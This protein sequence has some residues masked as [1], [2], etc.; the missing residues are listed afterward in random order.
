MADEM[1]RIKAQD[2]LMVNAPIPMA[3]A[4]TTMDSASLGR[5]AQR[6]SVLLTIPPANQK[7]ALLQVAGPYYAIR[8]ATCSF[9]LLGVFANMPRLKTHQKMLEQR[10]GDRIKGKMF[11]KPLNEPWLFGFEPEVDPAHPKHAE[12]RQAIL[13]MQPLIKKQKR[14]RFDQYSAD[15]R[16]NRKGL[17]EE[18][19]A[20]FANRVD[21]EEAIEET[22]KK[23]DAEA[24]KAIAAGGDE[25]PVITP[26][27]AVRNQDHFSFYCVWHADDTAK[28]GP[29]GKWVACILGAFDGPEN[30]FDYLSDT[31]QHEFDPKGI[32]CL[33]H[34]MYEWVNVEKERCTIAM[35]SLKVR[36]AFRTQRHQE[37]YDGRAKSR[38]LSQDIM[39]QQQQN[40]VLRASNPFSRTHPETRGGKDPHGADKIPLAVRA[41]QSA[42]RSAEIYCN[43]EAKEDNDD[44]Y[45]PNNKPLK[46]TDG[47]GESEGDDG[48][49]G[50]GGGGAK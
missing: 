9:R 46:N 33:N 1:A 11:S 35:S 43:T 49:G 38:A 20:R 3:Y 47:T 16:T 15:R 22:V 27:E 21:T 5:T 17:Q 29:V 14:E 13:D 40:G 32:K 36:T 34:E 39:R 8:R 37:L 48:T 7:F 28:R 42:H 4:S 25:P 6:G 26:A 10:F 18:E 30:A 44:E 2:P 19:F 31:L 41:Y 50:G 45:V 24:M 23:A 12:T